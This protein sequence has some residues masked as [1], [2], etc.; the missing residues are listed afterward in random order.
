MSHWKF[1]LEPRSQR[2]GASQAAG[3]FLQS[4]QSNSRAAAME[5]A[6]KTATA[7]TAARQERRVAKAKRARNTRTEI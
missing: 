7:P 6:A 2:S 1:S 5:A 4:Q 3:P